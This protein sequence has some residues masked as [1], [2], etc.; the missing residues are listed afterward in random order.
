[1]QVLKYFIPSRWHLV[2]SSPSPAT[3]QYSK[4]ISHSNSEYCMMNINDY[5]VFCPKAH[6]VC[7]SFSN[8]CE[9]DAVIISTINAFTSIFAATVIY[10][11]IGFRA[12]ERFDDCMAT[13]VFMTF[14]LLKAGICRSIINYLMIYSASVPQKHSDFTEHI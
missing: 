2:A 10:T 5:P 6:N 3:T 7:L 9:Q 4:Y 11:I 14:L 12:T 8:N 1:M 13:Y